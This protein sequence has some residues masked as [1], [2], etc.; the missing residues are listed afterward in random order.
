MRLTC[1]SSFDRKPDTVARSRDVDVRSCELGGWTTVFAAYT[2][3]VV[4]EAVFMLLV[5]KIPLVYLGFVVWWAIRAEP[6]PEEPA[7]LVPA[8]TDTPP[9][10]A[11]PRRSARAG[12]PRGPRHRTRPVRAGSR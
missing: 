12:E 3:R 4:W 8:V 7:A 5:L 6:R 2:G 9:D 10:G 1:I 11:R